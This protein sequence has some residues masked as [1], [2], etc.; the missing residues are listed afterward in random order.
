MIWNLALKK[1]FIETSCWW[2]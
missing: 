2:T 1:Y